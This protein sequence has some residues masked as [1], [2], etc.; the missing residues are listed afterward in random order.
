MTNGP[1]IE[2]EKGKGEKS[3]FEDLFSK[4]EQLFFFSEL[5]KSGARK[6]KKNNPKDI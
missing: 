2:S 6:G 4:S 1:C 3:F 5:Q